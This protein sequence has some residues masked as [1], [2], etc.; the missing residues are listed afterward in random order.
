MSLPA[1]SV[2][3]PTYDRGAVLVDTVRQLLDLST[4]PAEII[5]VDQTPTPEPEVSVA[6][7]RLVQAGRIRWERRDPPGITAAM[8]HGARLATGAVVLYLDDDIRL[9][10]EL[11]AVHAEAHRDGAASIVAGQVIQPWEEPLPE[12]ESGERPGREAQ[13][14]AFRF[15]ARVGCEVRRFCGGNVSI[16]RD[17]LFAL[18]GFDEN[19]K[20]VAYRFEADFAERAHRAGH[21][22]VFEP[23]ASI[24]HLRAARG[25]TRRFAGHLRTMAP[26]HSVGR[27]YYCLLHP[28][29]PGVLRHTLSEGART[30]A[31]RSHLRRPWWI[32][33]S[34]CAELTGL[35]WAAALRLR[36]PAHALSGVL[37]EAAS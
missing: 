20:G 22:I 26:W 17:T 2:V 25:G 31:A 11:V 12:G 5:L 13:P 34:A 33:M 16:R 24:E 10:G 32:P 27:Y 28:A 4:P 23:R 37:A 36:G 6:L 29:A 8:N 35:A 3:I 18:G 19:F 15:N 1:V 9:R 30:V 7:S 21:R 14:D